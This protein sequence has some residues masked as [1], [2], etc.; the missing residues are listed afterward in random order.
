MD[1]LANTIQMQIVNY[2][3]C[4]HVMRSDNYT[5]ECVHKQSPCTGI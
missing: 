3:G 4:G 5:T 1:R 2:E